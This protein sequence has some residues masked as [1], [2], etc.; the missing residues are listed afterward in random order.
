MLVTGCLARSSPTGFGTVLYTYSV[1][2]HGLGSMVWSPFMKIVRHLSAA[3]LM[4]A[5]L[6]TTLPAQTQ[7]SEPRATHLGEVLKGPSGLERRLRDARKRIPAGYQ[8]AWDDGRL[9]PL[10]GAGVASG[11]KAMRKI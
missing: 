1:L 3:L 2:R 6:P 7:H 5:V 9:N 10:R 8:A 11:E 4:S